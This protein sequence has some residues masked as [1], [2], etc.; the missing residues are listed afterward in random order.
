MMAMGR[1]ARL[2]GPGGPLAAALDRYEEREGQLAMANAVERTLAGDRVLLCE[3]G[4]G[5]GKTLAYLVPAILSGRKV[6]VSTATKAL[7]DQIYTKDLPLIAEHL[8]LRP[9]AALVK[10]LGNY[11]CLRRYNELRKSPDAGRAEVRRALPL[12]ERW[13]KETETG[14]VAELASLP[15]GDPIWREVSSSSETRLGSSCPYNEE[16]FVTGM[17]REAEEAQLLVV[18]HHL[19]FAD[20][21]VKMAAAKRGFAGARALPNYDAVIFDEAHQLEEIA[22][23]FFGVRLSRA[24]VEAMLRDADR[25]FLAAGLTDPV[26][27]R[28]QGAGLT[29]ALRSSSEALF[30]ELSRVAAG[31]DL[32]GEGR[33]PLPHDVWSGELLGAY[34]R[35]DDGLEAL[36]NYAANVSSDEAVRLVSQRAGQMREDAAK[37]VDPASN[38]VTWAEARGRGAAGREAALSRADI[39]VGASPVD[40]GWIFRDQVFERIG[41]VVLTSATLTTGGFEKKPS[42]YAQISAARSSES[43]GGER[44]EEAASG[45]ALGALGAVDALGALGAG[46]AL[47]TTAGSSRFRF[48]RARMG[49]DARVTV[50]VEELEVPSPFDYATSALLYT[51][52]D[53]PEVSEGAFI[54]RAVERTREL[55]E[56]SGGGAFV[57]CTSNRSLAAFARGLSERLGEAP[58]VQGEAPKGALLRR[59]RAARDAVLVA[60]MSFWEGVDVPGEALRLVVIEKLPFAVPSDPVVAARCAALEAQGRQPFLEYSVPQAAI[61][62]KQG[63]GRLIRTRTDR[64]VVAILDRRV[65]T[66]GYGRVLLDSLPPAPRTERLDDVR[67]FWKARSGNTEG[68]GAG[69]E[70]A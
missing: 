23:S 14:D 24:R 64:G 59:F 57:L 33:I 19:F 55:V 35:L 50:P 27:G 21:A 5:T 56:M 17:R 37:I 60:T 58:L 2:L 69:G 11:L 36:V 34:H 62:L 30:G 22:T 25:A 28:G 54:A 53:L 49:L 44:G 10:G 48:L 9:R 70:S 18:N 63:F 38:Q 42:G 51:P 8:G 67:A 45:G 66:R 39:A 65:R 52:R 26:F 68:G 29:Q 61:T 3:A 4:T 7:E 16:C 40:L 47:E 20:L 13:A 41:S 15:E 31:A 43:G 6:V 46:G 32:R 12:I 1:A